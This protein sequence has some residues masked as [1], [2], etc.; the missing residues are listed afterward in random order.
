[1]AHQPPSRRKCL[2]TTVP[3]RQQHT[4]TFAGLVALYLRNP[5]F[6]HHVVLNVLEFLGYY[7]DFKQ[8][9]HMTA[10]FPPIHPPA[11]FYSIQFLVQ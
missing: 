4:K 3:I 1:M 8:V 7:K 2:L 6:F 10:A 9:L 5:N 11:A